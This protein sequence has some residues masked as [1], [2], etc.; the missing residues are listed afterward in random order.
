MT[1]ILIDLCL[2]DF[3]YETLN[4]FTDQFNVK[5][6]KPQLINFPSPSDTEYYI[7]EGSNENLTNCL[8]EYGFDDESIDDTIK[9]YSDETI[10]DEILKNHSK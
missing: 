8:T 1:K 3:P 4:E 10:L 7:L 5:T 2:N 6:T 9:T